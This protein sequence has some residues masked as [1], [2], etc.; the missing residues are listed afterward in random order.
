MPRFASRSRR[1]MAE[2]WIRIAFILAFGG[3][4]FAFYRAAARAE[5][6]GDRRRA[7]IFG[8]AC[9]ATLIAGVVIGYYFDIFED[10]EDDDDD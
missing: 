6:N 1:T 8:I 2:F 7:I 9:I 3:G 10:D 5:R 4:C